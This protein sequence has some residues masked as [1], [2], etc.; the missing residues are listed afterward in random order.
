MSESLD[1]KVGDTVRVSYAGR[2]YEGKID[3]LMFVNVVVA[4]TCKNGNTKRI[5]VRK[6]HLRWEDANRRFVVSPPES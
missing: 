5:K 4:F 3:T 6:R 1:A 2:F